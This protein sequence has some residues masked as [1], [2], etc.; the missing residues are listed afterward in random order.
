MADNPY[1]V[2]DVNEAPTWRDIDVDGDCLIVRNRQTL[3]QRCI[4]SNQP[5]VSYSVTRKLLWRGK[6][7]HLVLTARECALTFFV[8]KV[9]RNWC[10]ASTLN[11]F[12]FIGAAVLTIYG[13]AEASAVL[14]ALAILTWFLV[15]VL[16][17]WVH[18]SSHRV[19]L[20][21]VDYAHGHFWIRGLSQEFLDQLRNEVHSPTGPGEGTT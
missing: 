9:S 20:K 14:V 1:A 7:F 3:P 11:S 5:A 12:A 10:A 19:D 21:I 16:F 15:V 18:F 6:S 8:T 2:T 4:I 13:M 17:T